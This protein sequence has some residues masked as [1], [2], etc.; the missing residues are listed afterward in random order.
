M[1]KGKATLGDHEIKDQREGETPGKNLPP[2]VNAK[3]ISQ[4]RNRL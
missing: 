1:E 2:K 3:E 4:R